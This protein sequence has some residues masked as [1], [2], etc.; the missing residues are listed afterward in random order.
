METPPV[1]YQPG[2]E[3]KLIRSAP[4]S[5]NGGGV[6]K[7]Q[8]KIGSIFRKVLE[9][10]CKEDLT[11]LGL[12]TSGI[13]AEDLALLTNE[14]VIALQI[15]AKALRGDT[16]AAQMIYDRTEGKPVQVNHNMNAELTYTEYLEKLADEE[17]AA[18][19]E[20]LS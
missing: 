16:A 19:E 5:N 3:G 20:L 14:E 10:R 1:Q 2:Y 11:M 9:Y 6:R 17:K 13:P 12:N 8:K 4:G 7:G 15:V 18:V